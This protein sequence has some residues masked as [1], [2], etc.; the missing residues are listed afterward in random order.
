MGGRRLTAAERLPKLVRRLHGFAASGMLADR[1]ASKAIKLI[2][3][4]GAHS[5]VDG[6]ISSAKEAAAVVPRLLGP[7]VL[8]RERVATLLV[9]LIQSPR[10]DAQLS[11]CEALTACC[12]FDVMKQEWVVHGGVEPLVTALSSESLAVQIAACIATESIGQHSDGRE[13]LAKTVA[14]RKLLAFARDELHPA[15]EKAAAA[16]AQVVGLDA[17]TSSSRSTYLHVAPTGSDGGANSIDAK[18]KWN[19]G[20]VT[21]LS[22]NGKATGGKAV[23]W[24]AAGGRGSGGRGVADGAGVAPDRSDGGE[25]TDMSGEMSNSEAV[26]SF[27]TMVSRGSALSRLE[28]YSLSEQ[29]GQ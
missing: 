25:V 6:Q 22:A 7:E 18:G 9:S 2:R 11:A 20:S 23:S 17:T 19:S 4:F 16:L 12:R 14:P 24:K 8:L 29:G 1:Q 27:I 10:A 15:Q 5:D 28:V 3:F 21:R 26:D 13:A